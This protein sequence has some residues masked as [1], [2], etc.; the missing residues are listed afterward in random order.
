MKYLNKNKYRIAIT[1]S[2][3][4]YVLLGITATVYAQQVNVP[5]T[6]SSGTT[7]SSSKVNENFQVLAQSMPGMKSGWGG[8][9][10]LS[11]SWQNITSVTVTPPADGMLLLLGTASVSITQGTS[12]GGAS[13]GFSSAKICMTETSGGGGDCNGARVTLDTNYTDGTQTYAPRLTVPATII[14]ST[15]V[16]KNTAVTWY[17]TAAKESQSVGSIV[18]DEGSISAI[19][20]PR[21]F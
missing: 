2:I 16:V 5:N 19:F 9:V 18:I 6:F 3:M 21:G 8:S 20:L 15:S 14:G 12:A 4:V 7:I 1:V 10:T 11:T 17:L 13:W